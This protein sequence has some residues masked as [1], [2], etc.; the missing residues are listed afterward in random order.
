MNNSQIANSHTANQRVL[1]GMLEVIGSLIMIDD[2]DQEFANLMREAIDS[3]YIQSR[4][5]QLEAEIAD[6]Q[7]RL[8]NMT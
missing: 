5:K 2:S 3:H 7:A 8:A 6:L 1:D 4:R